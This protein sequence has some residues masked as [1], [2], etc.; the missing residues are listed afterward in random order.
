V[1][2][3]A[4]PGPFDSEPIMAEA[5]APEQPAEET[6]LVEA[7]AKNLPLSHAAIAHTIGRIGYP[8]GRV[9]STSQILGG[10]FKVTC[11]SGDSYRAAPVH[12]R[13]RFKRL[14]SH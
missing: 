14:G 3:N 6:R 8:C 1:T 7:A 11:T 12:G 9:A 2:A 4:Q 10:M 5:T 13:Y